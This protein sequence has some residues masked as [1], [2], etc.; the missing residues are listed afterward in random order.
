MSNLIGSQLGPYDI[1]VCWAKV[2]WQP[3]T[4]HGMLQQDLK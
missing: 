2:A 4:V 3:F 1:L